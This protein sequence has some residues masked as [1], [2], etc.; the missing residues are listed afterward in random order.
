MFFICLPIA[1]ALLP[2][3]PV[4]FLLQGAG[5]IWLGFVIYFNGIYI[6]LC[7]VLEIASMIVHQKRE[8]GKLVCWY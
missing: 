8:H 2:D 6:I 3:S 5:N 7:L 4:K 1:G